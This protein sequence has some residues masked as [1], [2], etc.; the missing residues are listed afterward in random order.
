M[1][2]LKGAIYGWC[3]WRAGCMYLLQGLARTHVAS[4][5]RCNL[6]TRNWPGEGPR[7]RDTVLERVGCSGRGDDLLHGVNK[8]TLCPSSFCT[9]PHS[10]RQ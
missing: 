9:G 6:G 3:L 5:P 2:L 8:R 1:Y 10:R 7:C 4:Q